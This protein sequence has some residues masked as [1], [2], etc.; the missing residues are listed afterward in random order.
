LQQHRTL[1]NTSDSDKLTNVGEQNGAR[2]DDGDCQHSWIHLG[3]V[4]DL[5]VPDARANGAAPSTNKLLMTQRGAA[6]SHRSTV[7]GRHVIFHDNGSIS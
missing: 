4:T 5:Q 1:H 6:G 2:H 7:S 3:D